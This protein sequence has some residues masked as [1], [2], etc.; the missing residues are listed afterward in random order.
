MSGKTTPKLYNRKLQQQIFREALSPKGL[1]ARFAQ[2]RSVQEV[3]KSHWVPRDDKD[4]LDRK[5]S[6]K[7]TN[8]FDPKDEDL[9]SETDQPI[10]HMSDD[11][12]S[13]SNATPKSDG[14]STSKSSLAR[15]M[16]SSIY[17]DKI[18]ETLLNDD[19]YA[20]PDTPTSKHINPWSAH[21]YNTKMVNR[22]EQDPSIQQF[23]LLEDLTEGLVFP[24]ILD[25]KMGTRQHGVFA[26]PEKKLSQERKCE[27]STSKK[28]GV[29]ICGMQ[30]IVS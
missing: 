20:P 24:C 2:L 8:S 9:T 16:N 22:S 12:F 27:R 14:K 28:L 23:L 18:K 3:M 5:S 1:R 29:R 30:V 26:S 13:T 7:R 15:S 10:F 19:N 21:L 4:A 6:T 25:L 17:E 11:D